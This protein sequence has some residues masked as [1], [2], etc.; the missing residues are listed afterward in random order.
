MAQGGPGETQGSPRETLLYWQGK[1]AYTLV[2]FSKI[3]A[4]VIIFVMQG[5]SNYLL[6]PL[7][8]EETFSNI[9]ADV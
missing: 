6:N 2:T 1:L 3:D 5:E 8:K 9:L 4:F 7:V